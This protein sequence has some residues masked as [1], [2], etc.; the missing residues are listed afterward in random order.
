MEIFLHEI[1]KVFDFQWRG[2]ENENKPKDISLSMNQAVNNISQ[3]G[4]QCRLEK[5]KS[6][7]QTSA[8]VKQKYL[9]MKQSQLTMIQG[10][11]AIE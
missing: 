5:K 1:V 3:L 8:S 7:H 2:D 11:L 6:D 9:I 4:G 10:R